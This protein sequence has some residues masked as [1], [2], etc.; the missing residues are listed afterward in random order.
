MRDCAGVVFGQTAFEIFG[1]PPVEF[2]RSDEAFQNVG[3]KHKLEEG[4]PAIRPVRRSLSEG[5]SSEPEAE[6]SS[7]A[8]PTEDGGAEGSRTP[9]LLIANETLYQLSYDPNQFYTNDLRLHFSLPNFQLVR[10]FLPPAI[11]FRPQIVISI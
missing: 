9:D 6:Q 5:G 8:K 4:W 1:V 3:V 10:G 7:F 11:E 2:M